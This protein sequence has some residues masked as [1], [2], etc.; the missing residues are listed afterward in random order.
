MSFPSTADDQESNATQEECCSSGCA[1]NSRGLSNKTKG[2]VVLLVALV[3]VVVVLSG[4][5]R[6]AES[7]AS[8]NSATFNSETSSAAATAVSAAEATTS[9]STRASDEA[10]K[11][12]KQQSEVW[13]QTL[14]SLS[15]LNEVATNIDSV[16]VLVP[17]SDDKHTEAIRQEIAAAVRTARARG[18]KV[19]AYRLAGDSA[20]R[21]KLKAEVGV[22]CV[23]AMVK[24]AGAVPV[25]GEI[26]E[27]K[28]LE[29]LVTASRPPSC[30]PSGC[31]PTGCG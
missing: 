29:S 26:S 10:S 2:L 31:G 18:R 30:G 16:F 25:S 15:A 17:A 3:A 12:P 6:R 20:D 24:G 13:G 23:L 19:M 1:C 27:A 5:I 22:P 8:S 9:A 7:R 21:A 14:P 4:S 11:A 28:L